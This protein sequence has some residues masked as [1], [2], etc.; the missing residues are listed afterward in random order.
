VA[1]IGRDLH[2]DHAEIAANVRGD[3]ISVIDRDR[4]AAEATGSVV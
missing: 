3:F 4:L 2:D 1:H